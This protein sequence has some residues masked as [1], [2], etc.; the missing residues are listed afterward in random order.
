MDPTNAINPC[1]LTLTSHTSAKPRTFRTGAAAILAILAIFFSFGC[2]VKAEPANAAVKVGIGDNGWQMF[3]DPN[4][5]ALKTKISRTI[6]SWDWYQHQHE[7]EYFDA[8]MAAAKEAGVE[9]N[10]AFQRAE[11]RKSKL[12]SVAQFRTSLKTLLAQYPEIKVFTPWNEANHRSQPTANKAKQAALYYNEARKQCK[13]CKIVAADV[14]DQK[15]MVPWIKTFKKTAVNPKIYG[16]HSYSEV[17]RNIA[18][19]KSSMKE[20]LKNVKGEV[21][22]TEVGGLVAFSTMWK[23]NESRAAT[24]TKNVMKLAKRD[25]RIKR[26]YFYS[27]FGTPQP[28]KTPYLWDSGFVSPAG[29]PRP[30]YYT[31]RNWLNANPSDR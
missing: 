8:W 19:S 29:E 16:L 21:W 24:A 9:P 14:L 1:E 10:V 28:K 5:L 12:P 26:L 6:I 4:Y 27:W 7:K 17:N 3:K 15:N 22:L 20:L 23:Y 25:K 30:A 31:L 18:W 2:A 11:T 13:G